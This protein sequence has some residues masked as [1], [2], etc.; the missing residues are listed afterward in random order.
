[1]FFEWET[2]GLRKMNVQ[3]WFAENE[4]FFKE[5]AR[6]KHGQRR[7]LPDCCDQGP[8]KAEAVVRHHETPMGL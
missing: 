5:D 7:P 6:K 2:H 3:S 4:I 8:N 1:M